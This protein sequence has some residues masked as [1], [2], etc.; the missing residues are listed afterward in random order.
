VSRPIFYDPTGRRR[1]GFAIAV[2]A[3]VLLLTIATGLLA[4]TLV[5]ID[6][7]RPIALHHDSPAPMAAR[8]A[9]RLYRRGK[10]LIEGRP[11][12][13]SDNVAAGFYV[14]WDDSSTATLARHVDD[15]DWVVPGWLSVTG[16]A[17]QFRVE[18]DPQGHAILAAARHRPKLLPMLQNAQGADWDAANTAALL[19]SPAARG[20]L[21][22]QVEA[23]LEQAQADGL[24]FDIEAVPEAAQA[25][26]LRLLGEARARFAR[27]RWLIAVAAPALDPAWD[28]SAY[29]ARADRVFLML[30]DE[31]W[32]T[33]AP[34][35]IASQPWFVQTLA[36]DLRKVP[37]GKV[38]VGIGSYGYDW[39][40]HGAAR[41]ISVE[42]AMESAHDSSTSPIFDAA[43]GNPG[44]SYEEDGIAH[45]VWMLDAATAANQMRA[46]RALGVT[47][48]GL[49][50]L[51]AE[52]PSVWQIFGRHHHDTIDP[53]AI[54]S[55]PAGTSVDIQ[56]PG[57]LLE[58]GSLPVAGRRQATVDR[59]DLIT[60]ERF[61]RLPLPYEIRR[62]GYR[63]GLV[64]LTFDDGPDPAWTPQILD[65]L[66]A[67]HAPAT[68]FVVGENALGQRALLAREIGEGHEV[69]NHSYTHPNLGDA[70]TV[71]T[72]LELNVT[73]RL[74]QAYTGRSLRLFRAPF[75]GDAEPTTADEL[76]PVMTAQRLGYLNVGLHVDPGDWQRPGVDAIV[77]NTVAGVMRGNADRSGNIVLL[78]DSGGDRAQTVAALPRIIDA[79]RVRGYRLVPV[80][81]LI[82]MS[83]AQVMPALSTRDRI[84]ARAD[85]AI[86]GA[87]EGVSG[88]LRVL[89]GIAIILGITRAI[90]LCGLA[91]RAARREADQVPPAIDPS[92][93]VSVLIPCF[94]EAKVIEASVRRV[95]DSRA[96]MPE[97]IVID[98][99]STD[100]TADV[101]ARAYAGEPR[102]RLLR[103]PNGGKARAL[104]HA[105]TVA[106]GEYIVALDADT[107]FTRDTI[108]RLVR[109]FDDPTVGAVAGNAKVGNRVN[110]VTRWQALE[111][112]T[113]QNLE[114]RALGALDAI[115]VVPGAVGAWRAAALRQAGGYPPDTLAEDQDLTIAIQRLGWRVTYDQSA[116][117]WTEAPE[118]FAG[119]ARQRFRWAYGT[120]QCIWKHRHVMLSGKPRGLALIGLPQ[121]VIFQLAFAI[122]S[123]II[124]LALVVSM[125]AT[126]LRIV[127]HGWA[128]ETGDLA[129]TGLY[130]ICFMAIDLL[131]G[132]IAFALERREDWRL[133]ALLLP[134]RIGYRQIMYWVVV[135]AIV[136]AV[137]GPQIGWG[138]L[139]RTG[140][141]AAG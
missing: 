72:E 13:R 5:K 24:F 44:F 119:L 92:R 110:L 88:L 63:P 104:N 28:L 96:V 126:A 69:G 93:F 14:P 17:H 82:G 7:P 115:T 101:V 66:K 62:S 57:E 21:L 113:A 30:Y 138:K 56:G 111:Y 125:V 53:R 97:V 4:A 114:R 12:P 95:L 76:G 32:P 19:R 40:G 141:V 68:F 79:L 16:P 31:H 128:A 35:P 8:L 6:T 102:V 41:A 20:R 133:I 10:W 52:D 109:W 59:H 81:A 106:E 136:Q 87:I 65:V 135:K 11:A 15:L 78:H 99:G 131:A 1:R 3:F 9:S 74:F 38:A 130:W 47:S 2:S 49:W 67:K 140:R 34:G 118:S 129:I 58:V 123:P 90:M 103:L 23:Y 36:A 117:A 91:L 83:P 46:A 84:I 54:E 86:F 42:E 122:L 43:S 50:R 107:Q 61:P 33:G 77:A 45:Q 132:A 22:D 48:F 134:Q 98:D 112:V 73:Q 55:I 89:F 124:D 120:V 25:D 26:Y 29:A 85:F 105:L 70:S 137:R 18:A 116:V 37:L 80:A 100:G 27:H 51:G 139:E 127:Q 121:A 94:N 64:A 39:P 71:Q 75:F 60:D 108:V